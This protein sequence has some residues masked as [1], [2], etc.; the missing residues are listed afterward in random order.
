MLDEVLSF[1]GRALM[2]GGDVAEEKRGGIVRKQ[3]AADQV[4]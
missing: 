3:R 1:W 2:R 4:R